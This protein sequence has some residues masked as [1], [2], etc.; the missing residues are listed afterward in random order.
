[1][2]GCNLIVAVQQASCVGH[3]AMRR[4]VLK[5][6]KRTMVQRINKTIMSMEEGFDVR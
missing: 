2:A 1:M 6:G 4:D 3:T 5:E